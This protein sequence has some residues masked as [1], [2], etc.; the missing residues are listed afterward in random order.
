MQVDVIPN[1]R[2]PRVLLSLNEDHLIPLPG[3]TLQWLNRAESVVYDLN[4]AGLAVSTTV[5][6]LAG[7]T[8]VDKIKIGASFDLALKIAGLEDPLPVKLKVVKLTAKIIGFA[9][10]TL[11]ANGRLMIEQT[12]KDALICLNLRQGSTDVL[13]PHLKSDVWWHGPFDTNIFIWKTAQGH[14]HKLVLEYDNLI[15]IYQNEAW[16]VV[17]SLAAASEAQGYLPPQFENHL[18]KVALGNGWQ[19]RL[20]RVLDESPDFTDRDLVLGLLK[21]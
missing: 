21:V 2:S 14:L 20:I 15:L 8:R 5:T 6:S 3:V 16:S 17:R 1:K 7:S 19:K 11:S 9:F 4:F 13:H 12:M 18:Q 10:D